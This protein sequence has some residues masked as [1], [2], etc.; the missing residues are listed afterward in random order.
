MTAD[1][2]AMLI[3]TVLIC[4]LV[5]ASRVVSTAVHVCR[6]VFRDGSKDQR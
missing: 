6:A 3:G 2:F 5:A 4:G 1:D